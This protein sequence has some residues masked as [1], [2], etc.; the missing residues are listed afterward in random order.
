MITVPNTD[1]MRLVLEIQNIGKVPAYFIVEHTSYL[2]DQAISLNN[3][4]ISSP[5]LA[6]MPQ[7]TFKYTAIKIDG[8]M[9]K[10]IRE[11]GFSRKIKCATRINYGISKQDVGEYF[12]EFEYT[13][14]PNNFP[15]TLIS[16]EYP[17]LWPLRRS[18]FK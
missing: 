1:F 8:D 9:Y 11:R 13:F 4:N 14:S 5:P 10:N 16:K 3:P 6:L 2:D 17:G 12:T 7:S 15:E 18:E